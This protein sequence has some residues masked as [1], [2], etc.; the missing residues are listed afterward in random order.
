ME[1]NVECIN[2]ATTVRQ[3]IST[4][5]TATL[6]ILVLAPFNFIFLFI[7]LVLITILLCGLWPLVFL[8][9]ITVPIVLFVVGLMLFN[10]GFHVFALLCILFFALGWGSMVLAIIVGLSIL[11]I[12]FFE[13]IVALL[14]WNISIIKKQMRS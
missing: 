4:V 8:L 7:P 2:A 11:T 5:F 10:I 13:G 6:A 9:G 12:L 3:K 1:N 14:K